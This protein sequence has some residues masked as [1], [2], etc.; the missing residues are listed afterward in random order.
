[1]GLSCDTLALPI[2]IRFISSHQKHLENA[3]VSGGTVSPLSVSITRAVENAQR[4][5]LKQI[6]EKFSADS[7][8]P[9][10]PPSAAGIYIMTFGSTVL[11]SM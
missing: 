8:G 6:T 1:M 11:H 3:I 5:F 7:I 10:R 9:D 4:A 2:C